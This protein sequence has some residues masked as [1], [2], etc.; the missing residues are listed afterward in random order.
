MLLF[1]FQCFPATS[2]VAIPKVIQLLN[3]I[4]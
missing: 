2:A 1:A 3:Q 4:A